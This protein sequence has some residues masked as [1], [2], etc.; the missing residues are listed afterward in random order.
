MVKKMHHK[1]AAVTLH[2]CSLPFHLGSWPQNIMTTQIQ[3]DTGNYEH[4]DPNEH[5]HV[6]EKVGTL[7]QVL[8]Y[9]HLLED[10]V[11]AIRLSIL[12]SMFFF[13]IYLSCFSAGPGTLNPRRKGE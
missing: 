3:M 7:S 12:K 8:S 11:L 1:T 9:A 6:Y 2:S 4:K 5:I 10:F 13:L